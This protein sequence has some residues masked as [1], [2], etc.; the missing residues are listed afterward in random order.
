M[1]V[2]RNEADIFGADLKSDAENVLRHA[3]FQIELGGDFFAEEK[4]VAILNMAAVFA[5]VGRDADSTS[6]LG[7]DGSSHGVGFGIRVIRRFAITRLTQGGYMVD[8]DSKT[9]HRW[10]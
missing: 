7:D 5:Q 8:V 2:F 1:A 3:H 10:F 6:P 4:N 9:W